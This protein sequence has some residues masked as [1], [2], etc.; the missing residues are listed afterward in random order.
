MVL[1]SCSKPSGGGEG[2]G[3]DEDAKPVATVGMAKAGPQTIENSITLTGSFVPSQGGLARVVPAAAGTIRQVL[4]KEG[5]TVRAGQLLA[6]V[7]L[8]VQ[9]GQLLSSAAAIQAAQAQATQAQI[10]LR[11]ATTDQDAALRSA[12]IGLDQAQLD[13]DDS[14]TQAELTLRQAEEDQN[15]LKR[16][17]RPQEI[18]QAAQATVQAQVARNQAASEYERDQALWPDGYVSRRQLEEAK[19]ALAT[20]DAALEAAK[21]NESLVREGARPEDL[22]SAAARTAAA[23]ATL[24]SVQKIGEEKV[25]LAATTLRQTKLA[26]AGLKAKMQDVVAAQSNIKQR[27]GDQAAAVGAVSLGEIRA[28]FSGKVVRR[29]LNPGDSADT[30]NPIFEI[31]ATGFKSDFVATALP[32]VADQVQAGF[33]AKVETSS[34]QV[35]GRVTGVSLADPSTG[36]A[37]IR[38]ACAGQ[39][40]NGEFGKA[41]VILSVSKGVLAV[42]DEAILNRDGKT[43]VMLAADGAAKQTEVDTGPSSGGFTQIVK[44]LK[45]GDSVVTSGGYELDDGQKIKTA[46]PAKA[47]DAG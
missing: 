42:P 41:H 5:D 7:D 8:P 2:G 15:K 40:V 18:A 9:K 37:S 21:A 31:A 17:A 3:A 25:R 23:R 10:N 19:T 27:L 46:E 44:G 43:V 33:S 22:R 29:Y 14:V 24:V 36:L 28:P 39:M 20:A 38:I 16:G 1:I 34:G 6:I 32:A 30:A 11:T 35:P 12:Q 45:A 4:V 26:A 13:R 47:E